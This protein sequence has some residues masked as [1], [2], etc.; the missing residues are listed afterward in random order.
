MLAIASLL[1]VWH[2]SHS[3]SYFVDK[4]FLFGSW[5]REQSQEL[6]HQFQGS[7]TPS[8]LTIP[9]PIFIFTHCDFF[10]FLQ[11]QYMARMTA[12]TN[13]MRTSTHT[14]I[15]MAAATPEDLLGWVEPVNGKRAFHTYYK[16]TT[17]PKSYLD[18]VWSVLITSTYIKYTEI[19]IV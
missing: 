19:S 2:F 1:V 18:W 7:L 10:R 4:S 16:I 15:P 9:P 17:S 14:V 3:L 13:S 6:L 11:K 8:I 5:C 12:N